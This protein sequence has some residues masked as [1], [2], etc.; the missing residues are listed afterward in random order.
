MNRRTLQHQA[1]LLLLVAVTLA[2]AWILLPFY[3]AILWGVVLAIIFSPIQ[4][5]LLVL[6]RQRRNLAAFTT[7]LL[8]LIAVSDCC[9]YS[10]GD[11]RCIV[12]GRGCKLL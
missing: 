8:F 2:F 12:G 3:G 1:L 7:L 6:M 4:H 5:R 10:I 11:D 9:F